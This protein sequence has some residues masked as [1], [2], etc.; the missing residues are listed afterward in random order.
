[1]VPNL[2]Y[3]EV[4]SDVGVVGS[5]TRFRK[6]RREVQDEFSSKFKER[7]KGFYSRYDWM[8]LEL[9]LFFCSG[10]SLLDIGPYNGAFLE[11][12]SRLGFSRLVGLDIHRHESLQLPKGAEFKLCDVKLMEFAGKKFDVICAMEILEHLPI[13][14][15]EPAIA[16][17]RSVS[18]GRI[19][20]SLP[21]KEPHPLYKEGQP[22][23]HKQSFDEEKILRLF[24]NA[25]FTL[26]EAGLGVPW[27]LIIE[28][29]KAKS[30]SKEFTLRSPKEILKALQS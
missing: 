8:R 19:L 1:M 15:V 5:F 23:G 14:D 21:F 16:K 25:F 22:T 18:Q 27:V 17:I 20:Y 28:D 13:E 7:G 26:V 29:Q 4:L 30:E 11:M 9:S 6:V 10:E 2:L 12:V 24:P 3:W